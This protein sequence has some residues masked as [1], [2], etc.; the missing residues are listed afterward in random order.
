[1]RRALLLAVLCVFTAASAATFAPSQP[2]GQT[3]NCATFYPQDA[4]KNYEEG[5]VTIDYDVDATGVVGNVR[6]KGTSGI[7][8]LDQA[9]VTCVSTAWKNTPATSD[10]VPVASP[11]H[12]VVIEF[13]MTPPSTPAEYVARGNAYEVRGLH[14][15]AIAD[16][17]AAIALW[18]LYAD[19]YRGRAASYESSGR[20]DLALRD[21]DA[22][23]SIPSPART[24]GNTHNC[25]DYY[26]EDARE[27]Y[28]EGDVIVGYDVAADGAIVN[29]SVKRTSG[30]GRLDEAAVTCVREHWKDTPAM[31]D[32]K[33][34][35][36]PQHLADIRFAL[37]GG[38]SS[39][40]FVELG[41]AYLKAGEYFGAV[42]AFSRAIA[43][44]PNAV[45]AYRGRAIAYD[46]LNR[47]DLA[48]ADRDKLVALRA[49]HPAG[50]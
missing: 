45:E 12:E 10:G 8:S 36:S 20:H 31:L 34:V 24:I 16:F 25:A 35:A 32:G 2:V 30:N 26:P 28:Q 7:K 41:L 44:D 47:F 18:P 13:A 19:A 15:R 6:V 49:A 33:P 23:K 3:H 5:S 4:A 39:G 14:D 27:D 38:V 50:N 48:S 9:A 22:L 1:M 37:E 21:L 29:V 40:N 43:K 42:Q 17:T 11:G 46:G